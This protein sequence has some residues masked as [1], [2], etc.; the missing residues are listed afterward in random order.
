[1]TLAG[2]SD[3]SIGGASLSLLTSGGAELS[4]SG[5]VL[6]SAGLASLIG[7][8]GIALINSGG[9]ATGIAVA[10][11]GAGALSLSS[12]GGAGVP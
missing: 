12:G 9:A 2:A 10:N 7:A 4:A 1:M 3:V 6:R 11:V 8:A 5:V